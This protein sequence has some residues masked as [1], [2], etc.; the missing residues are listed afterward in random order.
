MEFT[1]KLSKPE[2]KQLSVPDQKDYLEWLLGGKDVLLGATDVNGDMVVGE[3]QGP[4]T[5]EHLISQE[6]EPE[7]E[8]IL[9]QDPG[10]VP[11]TEKAELPPPGQPM[12]DGEDLP[13]SMKGELTDLSEPV[14]EPPAPVEPPAEPAKVEPYLRVNES[15]V[16]LSPE[17]AA[18]GFQAKD[19]T[20][21]AQRDELAVKRHENE[22]QQQQIDSLQARLGAE[23]PST[24]ETLATTQPTEPG[25]PPAPPADPLEPKVAPDSDHIYDLW[26]N[27]K[28]Y[29]AISVVVDHMTEELQ[30]AIALAKRLKELNADQY[31]E[32][33][34][35][36]DAPGIIEDVWTNTI[37]QEVDADHPDF[38]GWHTPGDPMNEEYRATFE[39]LND[40]YE[41]E[42]GESLRS[43]TSRGPQATKWVIERVLQEMGNGN[44][45]GEATTTTPSLP[46][47]NTGTRQTTAE[48]PQVGADGTISY[49]EAQEMAKTAAEIAVEATKAQAELHPYT[50]GPGAKGVTSSGGVEGMTAEQRKAMIKKDPSQFKKMM[51]AHPQFK[52]ATLNDLPR[53]LS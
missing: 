51:A 14:V 18:E 7:P 5:D 35:A 27:Q 45:T 2:M 25:E 1:K 43:I 13:A 38:A 3:P 9:S 22:L 8:K 32:R 24:P 19:D 29:E 6:P 48:A 12:D 34:M 17:D 53:H 15:T 46:N 47:Q 11:V 39:D 26:E 28:P 52:S 33:M 4:P 36:L 41:T 20:I 40:R 30:P 42:I 16:Y 10:A 23:P 21:V 44:G 37:H 31:I 50:E 49:T